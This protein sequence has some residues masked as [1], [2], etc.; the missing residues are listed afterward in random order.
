[1]G[2]LSEIAAFIKELYTEPLLALAL[3]TIFFCFLKGRAAL[4]VTSDVVGEVSHNMLLILF[5]PILHALLFGSIGLFSNYVYDGLGMPHVSAAFWGTISLPI[6]LIIGLVV[7]DFANYWSHR[8]MHTKF[9]WG[10]H[11]LHHSDEHMTWSTNYR[12][13]ILQIAVMQVFFIFLLGWLFLPPE[14]VALVAVTRNWYSNFIH[15]KSGW[16][17]GWFHKVLTSPNYHHWHHS[18]DPKAYGKNLSDMFPAWDIL[19]GTYYYPSKCSTET[20]VPGGPQGFLENQLYPFKYCAQGIARRWPVAWTF[21][22][23]STPS[24]IP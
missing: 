1:M 23:R 19:F 16:T 21:K 4:K 10:F 8:L 3:V 2:M 14:V 6:M 9:L 11:V 20:G 18:V 17:Y 15:S 5:N 22:K 7:M 24:Q 12:V 13:H